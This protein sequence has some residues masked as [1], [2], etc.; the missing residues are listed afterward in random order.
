MKKLFPVITALLFTAGCAT[1]HHLDS[2]KCEVIPVPPG[3]QNTNTLLDVKQRIENGGFVIFKVAN[4]ERMPLKVTLDLPMG[5]LEQTEYRFDFKHDTYFLMS[6]KGLRLS[7]D[8][9]RWADFTSR[10]ALKKVFG[11]KHGQFSFSFG[12]TSTTNEPP[13]MSVDIKVK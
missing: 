13:F 11:F 9:Q 6:R 10:G 2:T 12:F 8:G 5:A 3:I 1:V 7:P 4:G